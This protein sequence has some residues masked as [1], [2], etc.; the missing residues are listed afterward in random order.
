MAELR[1]A[2]EYRR[3]YDGGEALLGRGNIAMRY[4]RRSIPALFVAVGCCWAFANPCPARAE[5][6]QE[7]KDPVDVCQD[8]FQPGEWGKLTDCLQAALKKEEAALAKA[9]AAAGDRAAKS[10]DPKSSKPALDASNAQ[11]AKYKKAECDRRMAFVEGRN[12]PDVGELTCAIHMTAERV[13]ELQEE[14]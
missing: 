7:P 1:R 3:I 12:H 2:K 4:P 9:V 8:G 10:M 11:W 13:E 6:A 14:E 5:A